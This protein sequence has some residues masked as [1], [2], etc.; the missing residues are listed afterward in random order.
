MYIY[1]SQEHEL[2]ASNL[3]ETVKSLWMFDY[4][5]GMYSM[6]E[7]VLRLPYGPTYNS[8]DIYRIVPNF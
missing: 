5:V 3:T 8:T 7:N 1:L 2:L 6:S 4:D